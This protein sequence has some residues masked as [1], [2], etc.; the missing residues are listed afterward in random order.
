MHTR[1][2]NQ[3]PIYAYEHLFSPKVDLMVFLGPL[4]L[5]ALAVVLTQGLLAS[6]WAGFTKENI[7]TWFV[8]LY[9][10][11]FLVPHVYSTFY[12]VYVDR[13]LLPRSYNREI[14]IFI[15]MFIALFIIFFASNSLL[16]WIVY[17]DIFHNV[18]QQY[19]WV[20][21][22][23]RKQTDISRA[24]LFLDKLMLY[25][26]TL[27]PLLWWHGNPTEFGWMSKNDIVFFLPKWAAELS[28][29]IHWFIS[30]VF[31]ATYAYWYIKGRTIHLG[32]L[33][34]I[35]S[36]WVGYFVGIVYLPGYM[37]ALLLGF[38]HAFAYLF[39]VFNYCQTKYPEMK[40][41]RKFEYRF[42]S[43]FLYFYLLLIISSLLITRISTV[44]VVLTS[45]FHIPE[46]VT[47]WLI[48]TP[49]SI[50]V[51]HYYMDSVI[52]KIR[53]P[54]TSVVSYFGFK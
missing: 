48:V 9:F 26:V 23:Q 18:R 8:V 6:G 51:F 52:W 10:S 49:I 53:R 2:K 46:G 29:G 43:N 41:G 14:A 1:Q 42:F 7:S 54:E 17:W 21:L 22:S 38:N 47:S 12:K 16:S 31:I 36:T 35:F 4:A 3:D 34:V 5:G 32:K 37:K 30:T 13:S 28:L 40:Q 27:G 15:G 33:L 20:V 24:E 25:N 19:G 39:L 45:V 11:F 50:S 44:G